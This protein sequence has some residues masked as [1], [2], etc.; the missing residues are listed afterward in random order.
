[1]LPFIEVS[2]Q[3]KPGW[4]CRQMT[5]KP[6]ARLS[7]I[8]VDIHQMLL[9]II[10]RY[11]MVDHYMIQIELMDPSA[12]I[13]YTKSRVIN[14]PLCVRDIKKGSFVEELAAMFIF[15]DVGQES[16]VIDEAFNLSIDV[17][18]FDKSV[19]DS[20]DALKSMKSSGESKPSAAKKRRVKK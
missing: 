17:Y 2:N 3:Y 1:M 4:W 14:G 6:R 8:S 5:F 13:R 12:G 16:L 10:Q 11:R 19:M 9:H 18:Q 20:L 15:S 7:Y